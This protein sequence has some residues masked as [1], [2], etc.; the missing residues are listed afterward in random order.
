VR[1][2][3]FAF[4]PFRFVGFVGLRFAVGPAADLRADA[5]R[6]HNGGDHRGQATPE[7]TVGYRDVDVALVPVTK[8]GLPI[9]SVN[10][11]G[12]QDALSVFGQFDVGVN[13]ATAG[14][15]GVSLGKFFATGTAAS[16]LADGYRC[17][18]GAPA[19]TDPARCNVAAR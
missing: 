10:G 15:P 5:Q 8:A 17:H 12:F 4:S 16:R 14:L 3:Q 1:A 7:L 9:Q 6:R 11:S 18:V 13:A 2:A 19:N